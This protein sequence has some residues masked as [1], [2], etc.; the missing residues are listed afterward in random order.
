MTTAP[1]PTSRLWREAMLPT[2]DDA[3]RAR[4]AAS[5]ASTRQTADAIAA[6][7]ASDL[8]EFTVHDG[9]HLD[10]LWPLMD[11]IASRQPRHS[12]IPPLET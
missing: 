10:A 4:L 3:V 6:S 9:T 11:L 1:G 2:V 12:T 5:L 8:P 7:I